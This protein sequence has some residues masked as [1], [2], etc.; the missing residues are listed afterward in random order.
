MAL[1][2]WHCK[3]R[4]A[5]PC[6]ALAMAVVVVVVGGGVGAWEAGGTD[7]VNS[8]TQASLHGQ[9]PRAARILSGAAKEEV[10]RP[11]ELSTSLGVIAGVQEITEL[12][13]RSFFAFRGIPFAEAPVGR[14]RWEAPK[15]TSGRWAGGYLDAT[16]YRPFCP[17]YD[18]NTRQVLGEEDCLYLNVYTPVLPHQSPAKLP[19]LVFLHG[20]GYL[21]GAAS[22][23]GPHKLLRKDIVL[24]TVNYRLGAL[25]FLS[26]RDTTLP[27][28]YG[29]LDQVAALR[30][31]R[32]HVDQFGGDP[33]RVT[34]GGFSSGAA[35]VHL[36]LL[37]PLSK[38]L[39]SSAIMMSGA[40]NCLWSVARYPETGAYLLAED[41]DC[42]SASVYSMR[43]CLK[44]KTAQEIVTA[45]AE[46]HVVVDAGLRDEPFLPESVESLS[47]RPPL[48]P[49]VPLLLGGV[50]KEGLLYALTAI[51]FSEGGTN[52]K[53]LYE[54]AALYT[55]ESLWPN[56]TTAAA[57]AEI[58]AS[59]YYSSHAR[60]DLNTL[61]EEMTEVRVVRAS[62]LKAAVS[63]WSLRR[64]R[65]N[66][67]LYV[68]TAITSIESWRFIRW[69]QRGH[70]TRA[71]PTS[72]AMLGAEQKQPA[73]VTRAATN[74]VYLMEH[75]DPASPS[76]TAPLFRP[77]EGAGMAGLGQ[78]DLLSGASHGDDLAL[79]FTLPYR[80]GTPG[81]RDH[82]MSLLLTDMWAAFMYTGSPQ[83]GEASQLP[84]WEPL[85]PGEP[86]LYYTISF[87][88]TMSFKPF[89]NKEQNLWHQTLY[90]VDSRSEVSY[91][92]SV[93]TWAL[94]ALV[95]LL[96][97]VIVLVCVSVWML[98]R[99]D[100][101]PG[102]SL[103]LRHRISRNPSITGSF[104]T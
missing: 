92:F 30:W 63:S 65:Q 79:L 52:P 71:T 5:R 93:A 23:L 91:A 88:P 12:P 90:R 80:L 16:Q 76:Y 84:P 43:E 8:T 103:T 9:Q 22:S 57:V 85:R 34:L 101:Y 59:Y 73:P 60:H 95:L 62:S 72:P 96:A 31:V 54:E 28:N 99:K 58:V 42:S 21:M 50:P 10:R 32:M 104:N 75:R 87:S 6:V 47:A 41:L 19:V 40:A 46:R 39:F 20:G 69:Q 64:L 7:G 81:P 66:S 18:P 70:V 86:V 36:H 51:V 67:S 1:R 17:Q 89:R 27:G 97:V 15:E 45:Q 102:G 37:S 35:L 68:S 83:E 11:F 2:G 29:A 44:D 38:D 77:A 25:G 61:A 74:N 14:L 48:R 49:A 3:G 100:K 56:T 53:E 98:R 94:L 24:V 33:T 78:S 13:H 55:V 4:P 26:T 82:Q